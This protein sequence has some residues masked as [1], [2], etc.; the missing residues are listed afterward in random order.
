MP[1]APTSL[2]RR[3]SAPGSTNAIHGEKPGQTA[4][5]ADADTPLVSYSQEPSQKRDAPS[6][7]SSVPSFADALTPFIRS[8][9]AFATR[10][11]ELGTW[12]ST[13]WLWVAVYA[14]FFQCIDSA[15]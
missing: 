5:G 12:S 8:L 6:C 13:R 7:R 11:E 3:L 15:L 4:G 14:F 10:F 2:Q 1:R 9:S